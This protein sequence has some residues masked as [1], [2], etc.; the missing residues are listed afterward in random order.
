MGFVFAI[1]IFFMVIVF[2]VIIVGGWILVGLGRGV[3]RV[4]F[5]S[6]VQPRRQP[7]VIATSA[8]AICGR[9]GC[10]EE[11]PE[12]AQFC[13]RCGEPLPRRGSRGLRVA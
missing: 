6:S 4:L 3:K 13:R 11:N 8:S 7:A 10:C 5:G 12:H 9:S 2:A 1:L